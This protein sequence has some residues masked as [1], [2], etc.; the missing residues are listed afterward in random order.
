MLPARWCFCP[1]DSRHGGGGT[2][3]AIGVL[4]AG[5]ETRGTLEKVYLGPESCLEQV[6]QGYKYSSPRGHRR[7]VFFQF[8]ASLQSIQRRA[9]LDIESKSP[10]PHEALLARDPISGDCRTLPL[11]HLCV[12]TMFP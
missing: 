5:C 1:K 7:F 3:P 11:V 4:T 6:L 10:G 12:P 9:S 8:E 2:P